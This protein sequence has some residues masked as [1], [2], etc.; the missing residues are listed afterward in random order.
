MTKV[1]DIHI[2]TFLFFLHFLPTECVATSATAIVG[3]LRLLST[4]VSPQ[5][6]Q[7]WQVILPGRSFCTPRPCIF[8]C[9]R[10]GEGGGRGCCDCGRFARERVRPI[11]GSPVSAR[12]CCIHTCL[13]LIGSGRRIQGLCMIRSKPRIVQDVSHHWTP[14]SCC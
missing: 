2:P 5:C 12:H 7:L 9:C 10:R 13:P 11:L 6:E 8:L 3:R 14:G 4:S 1:H